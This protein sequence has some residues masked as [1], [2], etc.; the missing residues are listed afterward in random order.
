MFADS[1]PDTFSSKEAARYVR[2]RRKAL[3]ITAVAL[4]SSCGTSAEFY[5]NRV[6]ADNIICPRGMSPYHLPGVMA[7]RP[8]ARQ[9]MVC[10]S[11]ER[12]RQTAT[13]SKSAGQQAKNSESK[14]A[15]QASGEPPV[16]AIKA[17]L[18]F[19]APGT[20]W[21]GRFISAKGVTTTTLYTV[22]DDGTHAGKPVHRRSGGKS[23]NVYDKGTANHVATLR[24][25][26]ETESYTPHAGT[27]DWPLYVGKSWKAHYIYRNLVRQTTIDP[28]QREYRV[29]AYEKVV[30]P[31]G[32]WDAFRITNMHVNGT[33]SSTIWYAPDLKLI[34]KRI[35]ETTARHSSGITKTI[36]EVIEYPAKA[37]TP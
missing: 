13:A 2:I 30:V 28:V 21:M 18:G 12:M 22:L 10:M 17:D 14:V 27:F 24:D 33:S 29:E 25:D 32:T 36:Y 9:D 35:N 23:T 37:E 6:Q 16:G 4:M 15:A 8:H 3:F 31:G 5:E 11:D 34:V 19:P 26:K 20:R 7:Q 1:L